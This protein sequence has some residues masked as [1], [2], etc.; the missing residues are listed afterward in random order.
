MNEN[1]RRKEVLEERHQQLK[2]RMIGPGLVRPTTSLFLRSKTGIIL[3]VI[4]IAVILWR[5]IG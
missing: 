3:I 2:D 5:L 1:D 4:I